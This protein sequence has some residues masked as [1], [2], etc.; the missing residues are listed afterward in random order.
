MELIDHVLEIKKTLGELLESTKRTEKSLDTLTADVN[1]RFEEM[2]KRFYRHGERI[3]QTEQRLHTLEENTR[4]TEP[5]LAS[6][7]RNYQE[8]KEKRDVLHGYSKGKA[9]IMGGI[10]TAMLM[11]ANLL[12]PAVKT[13]VLNL[14]HKMGLM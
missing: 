5:R 9:V 1:R 14:L 10:V 11:V 2:E 8:I 12:A 6:L 4:L 7:E 3:G 13:F